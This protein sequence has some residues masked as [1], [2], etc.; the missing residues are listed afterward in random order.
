MEIGFSGVRYPD[1]Y[2][3]EAPELCSA[4]WIQVKENGL[5]QDARIRYQSIFPD[6]RFIAYGINMGG[7]KADPP[8]A[9]SSVA[10]RNIARPDSLMLELDQALSQAQ[11]EAVPP[12]NLNE[13]ALRQAYLNRLLS[14]IIVGPRNLEQLDSTMNYWRALDR[15]FS[16][17]G[18]RGSSNG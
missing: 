9:L 11:L 6:A 15:I 14:G 17:A 2:R 5:T 4:W 13:L 7:I 1:L 3:E 12:S 10:L 18:T 8:S 16:P